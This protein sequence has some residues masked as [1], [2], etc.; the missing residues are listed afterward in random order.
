M[1]YP[2]IKEL[3]MQQ[4]LLVELWKPKK[5]DVAGM[6]YYNKHNNTRTLRLKRPAR[7]LTADEIR[8]Q[9]EM[10]ALL[11]ALDSEAP[12]TEP[13][14][15]TDKQA[16]LG[17]LLSA[18]ITTQTTPRS[19]APKRPIVSSG[20]KK[21]DPNRPKKPQNAFMLYVADRRK[22][23][24]MIGLSASYVTRY[25]GA[26]WKN[27]SLVE[28]APYEKQYEKNKL[29]YEKVMR[30]YVPPDDSDSD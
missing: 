15:N 28:K 21:K 26:E 7:E 20:K 9:A 18:L 24:D 5:S 23:K 16:L 6:A 19:P 22:D 1:L 25:V 12:S 13:T 27:M 30:N 10:E 4:T 8:E 11:G 17:G 29:E 2:A 14:P 3:V